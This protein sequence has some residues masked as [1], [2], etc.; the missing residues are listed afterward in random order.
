M[1][2]KEGNEKSGNTYELLVTQLKALTEEEPL[3]LPNLSNASALLYETMDN[4]SWAGFYFVVDTGGTE[5]LV[6]GPFQGRPA[7][8]R[9]G[10]GRGVC[11]TAWDRD[12]I[13]VVPDVRDFPGHIACDAAS[14]SEIVIPLHRADG[15]VAGV[16]DIDSTAKGRFSD[17]DAA[18]LKEFAAGIE[19]WCFSERWNR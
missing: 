3:P 7:C 18:G 4:I 6:L 8:I 16:L 12:E 15:T 2:M 5:E 1:E 9:I 14:A 11:G 13:M 17:E 10:R 19:R